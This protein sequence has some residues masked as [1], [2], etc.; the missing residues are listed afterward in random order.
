MI[1]AYADPPYLGQGKKLY[2]DHPEASEW[3]NPGTHIALIDRLREEF[4]DGWALSASSPSLRILLP[5]CPDDIRIAAW[6]KPFC[7]F[8][9]GV[10][11]CYAWEPVLFRGGRNKNHP[12]PGERRE[13]DHAEGF[14]GRIHHPEKRA[15]RSQAGEILPVGPGSAECPDG[16]YGD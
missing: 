1:F 4:P 16:G 3:D 9:K 13:A 8:K 6:V 15:D 5:V 7:A 14:P 10:R 2:G 12:P 11:P